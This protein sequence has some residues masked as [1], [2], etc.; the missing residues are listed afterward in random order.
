MRR[1]GGLREH[2]SGLQEA[3]ERI[4][5][6]SIRAVSGGL[7]Q[8]GPPDTSRDQGQQFL[9]EPGIGPDPVG[10]FIQHRRCP[11]A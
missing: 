5:I 8:G 11:C 4:V 7:A 6:E 9:L 3:G 1:L 2:R 10:Q